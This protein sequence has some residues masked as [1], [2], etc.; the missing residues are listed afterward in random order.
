MSEPVQEAVHVMEAYT[1]TEKG[2]RRA[3][4]RGLVFHATFTP[5]AEA[6]ALTTA[7]HFQGGPLHTLVRLSNAS[8]SPHAPDRV[9]DRVGK[10]LGLA[11]R[12]ELPSGGHAT[13]AAANIPVFLARTPEEFIQLTTAQRPEGPQRKPKLLRVL[14]H[15]VKHLGAIRGLKGVFALKPT[16]SFAHERFNG[17]HAYHLRDAAG[18]RRTIR[19]RW[20]P[21]AGAH[22]LSEAQAAS[23]PS[24]YLLDEIHARV[25][26][27]RVEWTLQF[28]MAQPGDP[29]DDATR[30][31]PEDRP[32]VTAGTLVL[33][34][35][36]EDQRES[37]LFVFD[38]AGV[39]PGIELSDDP[40]LHFRAKVY[41]ESHLRRSHETKP[42]PKPADLRQ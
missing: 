13:W 42:E 10:V 25:A 34:R 18:Q 8:G 7:E 19:Y 16:P 37:E 29:T 1:G 31:W 32:L 28:Q 11:V 33:E 3:H 35:P 38:P 36:Y 40:I 26:R 27:E 21:R 14:G 6:R 4:P 41:R 20:T 2:Y 9:N 23:M 24:Q 15:L 5:S 22:P 17:I 30:A 12:F 39:V